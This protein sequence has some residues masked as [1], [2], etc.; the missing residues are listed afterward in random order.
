MSMPRVRG[1]APVGLPVC[2]PPRLVQRL[3]ASPPRLYWPPVLVA[4]AVSAVLILGTTAAG[5]VYACTRG[6]DEPPDTE[7]ASSPKQ[8]SPAPVAVPPK[9]KVLPPAPAPRPVVVARAKA[10]APLLP[11]RS[12]PKPVAPPVPEPPPPEPPAQPVVA[13][14][15]P[16]ARGSFG[17]CV[18]F[19]ASPLAAA[20]LAREQQKLLFVLHV[21]GDFEDSRFT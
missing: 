6:P 7:A 21:S 3:S 19:A 2:P 11:E 15:P 14:A 20:R 10:P 12:P 9:T 16:A 8:E 4:A 13:A 18:E 1:T 17:T 5:V